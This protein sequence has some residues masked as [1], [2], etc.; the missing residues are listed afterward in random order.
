MQVQSVQSLSQTSG[1]GNT[2]RDEKESKKLYENSAKK[3]SQHNLVSQLGAFL[4][5]RERSE[6]ATIRILKKLG[7]PSEREDLTLVYAIMGG[8]FREKKQKYLNLQF[9][10]KLGQPCF[11]E[12]HFPIIMSA[13]KRQNRV[14]L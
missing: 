7:L 3:N 5:S 11:F 1:R 8:V 12:E 13:L 14:S 9:L 6:P 2:S 4:R 10:K